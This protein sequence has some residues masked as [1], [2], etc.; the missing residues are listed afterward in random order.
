MKIP[1]NDL[2]TGYAPIDNPPPTSLELEEL[3]SFITISSVVCAIAFFFGLW[4]LGAYTLLGFLVMAG[5]CWLFGMFMRSTNNFST[6]ST[7]QA[8]VLARFVRDG[9]LP[10]SGVRY[11]RDVIE[12]GRQLS[13]SEALQL[14][15]LGESESIR[16][17]REELYAIVKGKEVI[18]ADAADS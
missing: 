13:V 5:S 16:R 15:E 8:Q 14:I 9:V 2:F 18:T 17:G 4:M 7:P 12:L 11:I 1:R 10:E 6:H 3:K